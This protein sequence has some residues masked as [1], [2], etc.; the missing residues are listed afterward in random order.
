MN[1]SVIDDKDVLIKT[2]REL[3]FSYHETVD[4][5]N[6]SLVEARN[7]RSLWRGKNG[8]GNALIQIGASLFL[9]PIPIVTEALGLILMSAGLFQSKIQGPPL[10]IEDI[11][12][13]CEEI[14]KELSRILQ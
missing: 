4:L 5:L 8:K 3:G 14:S 12:D 11:Y 1:L 13:T 6:N 10:Y 7:S 9:V 2:V